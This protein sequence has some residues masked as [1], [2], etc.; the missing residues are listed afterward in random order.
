ML[1][2]EMKQWSYFCFFPPEGPSDKVLEECRSNCMAR[3]PSR[4]GLGNL[5]QNPFLEE[6]ENAGRK[7]FYIGS[8]KLTGPEDCLER[9]GS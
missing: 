9:G 1:Y 7:G 3:E 4:Q 2:V 5:T 8:N 6:G